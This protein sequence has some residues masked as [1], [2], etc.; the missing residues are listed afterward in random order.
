MVNIT[1]SNLVIVGLDK[2][3][4]KGKQLEGVKA[5]ELKKTKLRM[6]CKIVVQP[7][8]N[9]PAIIQEIFDSGVQIKEAK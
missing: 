3:F 4:W 6:E 7:N 2:I 1:Q 5:I 9:D 8:L